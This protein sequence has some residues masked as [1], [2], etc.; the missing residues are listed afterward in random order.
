M[1]CESAFGAQ[2][3]SFYVHSSRPHVSHESARAS[4]LRT[5]LGAVAGQT[6]AR[7]TSSRQSTTTTRRTVRD[8]FLR[9][10]YS[11]P[12]VFRVPDRRLCHSTAT[13]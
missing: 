3:G 11:Q 8:I 4:W 12:V 1:E 9:V 5:R 7:R 13:R 2:P 10:W 6:L